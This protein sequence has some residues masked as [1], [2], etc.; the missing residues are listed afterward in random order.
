MGARLKG[1][2]LAQRG[3]EAARRRGAASARMRRRGGAL[4]GG[5]WLLVALAVLLAAS[6]VALKGRAGSPDPSPAAAAAESEGGSQEESETEGSP[7]PQVDWGFWESVN[8]AVVGWISIPGTGVSQPIVQAPA[9]DPTFYL[10]HDA[11]GAWNPYGAVYLD[12]KC[13]ED[14]LLDSRNAVVCG[15]NC[16]DGSMF[17]E[18]ARYGEEGWAREH[19]LVLLQT[20]AG[21][22]TCRVLFARTVDNARASKRTSFSDE[23]DWERWY[24][25]ER[26]RASVVL[27]GKSIPRQTLT[28]ATCSYR[29]FAD[30]RTVAVASIERSG[31]GA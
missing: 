31:D 18:V 7:W 17:A 20:P 4:V 13:A 16:D 5:G 19:P 30:E 15:H 23:D 6:L 11:T 25:E 8:P 2:L 29:S 26:S 27:D 12:A 10:D 9:E 24:A 14:G 28:L 21:K 3:S 1:G 22:A